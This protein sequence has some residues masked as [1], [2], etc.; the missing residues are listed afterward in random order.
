V[1]E[2]PLPSTENPILRI[3]RAIAPFLDVENG[4]WVAGGA[5]RRLAS[6][7]TDISV[8][9]I[10]IFFPN[11]E[12]YNW[13]VRYFQSAN[14]K[15]FFPFKVEDE[16]STP[17]GVIFKVRFD[18][19]VYAFQLLNK[20]YFENL[21]ELFDDFDFTICMFATDGYSLVGEERADDDLLARKLVIHK[22]PPKPKAA[23]LAK[24]CSQGFSPEPGVI[25]AMF[26]VDTTRFF[27]DS[28]LTCDEY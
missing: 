1:K 12:I 26:G 16:M 2:L 15:D 20:R 9:D 10:D 24:Y 17:N 19:K 22:S 18:E 3:I 11:L 27:P 7:E 5:A 23:R 13:A 28:N 21:P 14:S 6:W 25:S 4:P 8:S